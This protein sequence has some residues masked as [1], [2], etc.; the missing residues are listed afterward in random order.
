VECRDYIANLLS[1][2]AD[3]ELS[4]SELSRA[5]DHVKRC[6]RCRARLA[7]ERELKAIIRRSVRQVPAPAQVREG[8]LGAIDREFARHKVS[9]LRRPAL[10]VPMAIA[11]SIV[12]TVVSVR[13]LHTPVEQQ[14]T[15]HPGGVP[16]FDL[17]I[18]KFESFNRAFKPN[19]PS[20]SF[21]DIAGAYVDAHMPGFIWNFNGSG[22]RLVG[23]RLDKLSDGR[24]V[25]YTFYK[26]GDS[27]IL[28]TRYKVTDATPPAGAVQAVGGHLFYT[29]YGYS[30]CYSYS[31]IGNFV[32]L[33]VMHRPV[34][35]LLQT[36][37]VASE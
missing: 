34:D 18:A 33:L 32:C 12:L 37:V 15:L 24:S 3:G 27:A 14:V 31:P 20:D 19:V 21:G 4:G 30:I 7:R 11:A 36:V 28:C 8:V 9:W 5:D 1:A 13:V 22:M 26:G 6:E 35:E 16:D 23:G 25:T 17:A 2:H 29:Y 10:W